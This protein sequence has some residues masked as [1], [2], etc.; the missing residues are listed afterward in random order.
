MNKDHMIQM[1]KDQL[2]GNQQKQE[3]LM[4]KVE[5]LTGDNCALES[6]LGA[7]RSDAKEARQSIKVKH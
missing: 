7:S 4:D 3:Y 1:S 5:K 6:E 2:V